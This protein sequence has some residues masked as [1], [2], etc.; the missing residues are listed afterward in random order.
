MKQ[1]EREESV[2]IKSP[3]MIAVAGGW[4]YIGQQFIHAALRQGLEVHVFDPGPLPKSLCSALIVR[5]P[6][7]RAFYQLP[8]DIFHI[9]LHPQQRDTGLEALYERATRGEAMLVLNE[10]PMTDPTQPE[11][12]GRIISA[13]QRSGLCLLYDFL[14]L[15]DP[16]TA[17]IR[18]FLGKFKRVQLHE[19]WMY[20]SK[21]REDPSNPRNYKLMVP[22]QYQ[23]TVHC[24]AF[25]LHLLA[26]TNGGLDSI[27]EQGLTISGSSERYDAPNPEAYPEPVDGKVDCVM[28]LGALKA[29]IHT[30]FKSG[31]KFT[32]RRTIKGMG[33]GQPFTI[34]AEYLEGEKHLRINGVDQSISKEASGYENAILQIWSWYRTVN[35]DELMGGDLYP[36]PTFAQYTYL[37][38]AMLWDSCATNETVTAQSKDQ[39][40]NYRCQFPGSGRVL[41]ACK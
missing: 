20:R 15:F 39:V 28:R 25:L 27:W 38:S 31:A 17:R 16:M 29:K 8:A 4:G 9:A 33:D 1:D 40:L 22:I 35:H 30:D 14:E 32:K 18:D 10:K 5:V 12:C 2:A 36:N 6:E 34:E 3:K 11:E 41:G 13:T 23:E 7:E 37:I 24:V 19:A 21:D 26:H